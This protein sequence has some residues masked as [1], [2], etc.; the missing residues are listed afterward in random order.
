MAEEKTLISVLTPTYN[1]E[2]ELRGLYSSLCGQSDSDFVWVICDDGSTDKTEAAIKE[3]INE[4]RI[5]IKYLKKPNGGKHTAINYAMGSI[6]TPLT[7]IVDSDDKLTP[8]AVAVIKSDYA[9]DY[10][11]G[12]CGFAYRRINGAGE[13]L[14]NKPVPVDGMVEDYCSCR[15]GRDIKGDMA[16]V[17]VT[18]CLK[19]FP[20]PEFEGERFM[21]EGVVWVAM[22]QK[23]KI[24]FYN[25][26][27]YVCDYL[28]GGLTVNRRKHNKSSPKGCMRL[29]EVHLAAELPLKYRVRAMLYYTVYGFFA[30]YSA[31]QLFKRS[32]KKPLFLLCLLP[33]AALYLKWKAE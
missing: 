25:R 3:L 11:K 14:T 1:R 23:Y 10:R 28:D 13:Y 2:K 18:E 30:G 29:G 22:A 32:K 21:S 15:L 9:R 27:V 8:D 19:E 6:D 7:F 20:F 5:R 31:P 17:W 12:I 24:V 4:G 33:S 16:E 26:A